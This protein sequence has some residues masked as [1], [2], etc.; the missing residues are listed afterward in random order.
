MD[1]SSKQKID[2]E[3]QALNDT[4]DQIDLIDIYRTFHLKVPE[5]TFFSSA[6]GKFSRIHHILSH[7]SNL[8][9]FKKI[10]MVS[11]IFSNHSAMKVE[12]NYKNKIGKFT[13]MLQLNK[14]RKKSMGQ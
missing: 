4:T 11:G 13:N 9:K 7:K 2:K 12:I 10:E 1:I 8:R 14:L 3:T 6:H 5:Y